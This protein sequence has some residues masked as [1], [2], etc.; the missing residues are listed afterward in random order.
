MSND[1]ALQQAREEEYRRKRTLMADSYNDACSDHV[2][3]IAS[4]MKPLGEEEAKAHRAKY[5]LRPPSQPYQDEQDA[6]QTRILREELDRQLAK[7]GLPIP[8]TYTPPADNGNRARRTDAKVSDP[9]NKG[10]DALLKERRARYGDYTEIASMVQTMKEVIRHGSSWQKMDADMR[11]SLDMVIHKIGRIANS[12]PEYADS[13]VD[14][15][16]YAR[17]VA[18]RLEGEA[19]A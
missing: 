17:L 14:I 11:E 4:M 6:E 7:A 9:V 5:N 10:I 18:D 1:Y 19:A 8:P 15:A 12:N 3:D 13:W 16:G 2:R